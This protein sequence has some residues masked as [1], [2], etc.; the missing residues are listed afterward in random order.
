MARSTVMDGGVSR[1]MEGGREGRR[2]G[3]K[4]GRKEGANMDPRLT[5]PR[6][7]FTYSC[8]VVFGGVNVESLGGC[9]FVVTCNL[10]PSWPLFLEL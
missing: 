4:E 9:G 10:A 2:G 6:V 3:G 5:T 8:R 7:L 1:V